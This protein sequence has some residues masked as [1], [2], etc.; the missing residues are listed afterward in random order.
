MNSL[1]IAN[2][3]TDFAD[4]AVLLPLAIVVAI[5]LAVGGWWRGAVGWTLAVGVTLGFTLLLKLVFLACGHLLPSVMMRSPSGHVAASGAVYGGLFAVAARVSGRPTGRHGRLWQSLFTLAVI[6]AIGASRL[7]LG[8]HTWPEVL[9]GG[10]IAM[11][12]AV[13]A[14]RFMGRPPRSLALRPLGATAILVVSLLHG[15]RLPA[16]AAIGRAATDFW[17]LSQCR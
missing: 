15:L 5:G 14:D 16:E 4:Q 13:A 8:A 17:P 3:V 12:G 2:Y 1:S 9:A 11:A 7:V 6:V 10:M